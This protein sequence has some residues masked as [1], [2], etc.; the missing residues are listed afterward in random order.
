MASATLAGY[1]DAGMLARRAVALAGAL[2]RRD[3]TEPVTRA[4]K[5]VL[6][7]LP[8]HLTTAQVGAR[9]FVSRA[10]VKTHLRAIYRKLGV[11]SRAEAVARARDLGLLK[12]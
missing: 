6:E 5:R 10:T 4:E 11:G 2:E 3:L 9:L 7:L 8:T 1:P 12:S